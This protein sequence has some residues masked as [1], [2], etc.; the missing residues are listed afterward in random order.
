MLSETLEKQNTFSSTIILLGDNKYRL[1]ERKQQIKTTDQ[2]SPQSWNRNTI[3]LQSTRITANSQTSIGLICTNLPT[4]DV[5]TMVLDTV[6]AD[7]TAQTYS[8]ATNIKNA[9]N[10]ACTKPSFKKEN[11]DLLAA[12]LEN[13]S[14][15]DVFN[16]P[17]KLIQLTTC[18]CVPLLGP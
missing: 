17:T 5:N 11:L 4:T 16:A 1:L 6:L 3:Y 12:I 9:P 8:I 10:N 14:W 13:E 7:D 15:T 18:S 2:H